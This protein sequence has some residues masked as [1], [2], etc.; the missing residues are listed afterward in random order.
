MMQAR[1]DHL[2]DVVAIK[3]R[4][5][6]FSERVGCAAGLIL[7]QTGEIDAARVR[8]GYSWGLS[9]KWHIGKMLSSKDTHLEEKFDDQFLGRCC[10]REYFVEELVRPYS[11]LSGS[12]ATPTLSSCVHTGGLR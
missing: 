9:C 5:L 8:I 1:N 3:E 6:S 2:G 10:S 11:S 7:V 12:L 4:S